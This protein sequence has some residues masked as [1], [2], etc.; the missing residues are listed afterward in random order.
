MGFK[1]IP[2]TTIQLFRSNGVDVIFQ[3]TDL[4][5][6]KQMLAFTKK[7]PELATANKDGIVKFQIPPEIFKLIAEAYDK[8]N[9]HYLADRMGGKSKKKKNKDKEK[10]VR[11][12]RKTKDKILKV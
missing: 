3:P 7:I 4:L 8:G 12:K 10:K 6:S 2:D 11:Q 5:I 9:T 1:V